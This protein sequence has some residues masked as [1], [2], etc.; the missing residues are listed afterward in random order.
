MK[1]ET[2]YHMENLPQICLLNK[3]LLY[4]IVGFRNYVGQKLLADAATGVY[5]KPGGDVVIS[6]FPMIIDNPEICE[7][8]I[9]TWSDEVWTKLNA[10]QQV[11]IKVVMQKTEDFIKRIYPLL[12]ADEFKFN[13][14]D[15][16]HSAC[17]DPLLMS[18]R[19]QLLDSALRYGQSQPARG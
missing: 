4:F 5:K 17:A 3:R 16:T 15:P 19:K 7:A 1:E 14:A 8:V 18:K 2:Q 9:L 11:D 10:V 13:P 12:Y 6:T